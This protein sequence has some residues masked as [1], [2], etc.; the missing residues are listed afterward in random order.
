MYTYAWFNDICELRENGSLYDNYYIYPDPY[1]RALKPIF[2]RYIQ[3]KILKLSHICTRIH[4]L[5]LFLS[6]YTLSFLHAYT[7]K[8]AITNKFLSLQYFCL[9]LLYACCIHSKHYSFLRFGIIFKAINSTEH[10]F[11]LFLLFFFLEW[12]LLL[13]FSLSLSLSFVFLLHSSA[14]Q[15]FYG[16]VLYHQPS[17]KK[18]FIFCCGF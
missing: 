5:S 1:T 13:G 6:I 8:G 3:D 12:N 18:K 4:S 17:N 16:V 15:F 2:Y 9:S 11:S 14:L 10:L 7:K